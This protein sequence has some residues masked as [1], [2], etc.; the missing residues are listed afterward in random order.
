VFN[1]VAAE[2][3]IAGE[4]RTAEDRLP[5]EARL[6]ADAR[7]AAT[8]AG[9]ADA[10]IGGDRRGL[11]SDRTPAMG[12][13]NRELP[14]VRVAARSVT[15]RIAG[16]TL[17]V[18]VAG[19][20]ADLEA[21]FTLNHAGARIWELLEHAVTRQRIVEIVL[22]EYAVSR[23]QAARDVSGFVDELRAAG[24]IDTRSA[25]LATEED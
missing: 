10:G 15:R 6:T 11:G 7:T 13:A 5:G 3:G 23:D 18:P 24:L 1:R 17:V 21:I 14:L 2:A 20:V 16:E 4:S 19:G 25:D 22:E 9:A 12:S 8:A